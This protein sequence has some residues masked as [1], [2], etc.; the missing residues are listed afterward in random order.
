[1]KTVNF[2]NHLTAFC[3]DHTT[4]SRRQNQTHKHASFLVSYKEI[5]SGKNLYDKESSLLICNLN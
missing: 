3:L 2:S 5:A 1:M 4:G